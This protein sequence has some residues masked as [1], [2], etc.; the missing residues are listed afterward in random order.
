MT[1]NAVRCLR[2]SYL[3]GHRKTHDGR[4]IEK[5]WRR[6]LAV[7]QEA[8]LDEQASDFA[9]WVTLEVLEGKSPSGELKFRLTDFRRKLYGRSGTEMGELQQKGTLYAAPIGEDIEN[10]EV[11][12]VAPAI[13]QPLRRFIEILNDGD[14]THFERLLIWAQYAYGITIQEI[15]DIIGVTESRVS[16]ISTATIGKLRGSLKKEGER[17][18]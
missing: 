13:S 2:R 8:G 17:D 16:Q 10:G 9:A 11:Q 15:G 7:G 5:L 6:A 18:V 14:L 3:K 4:R 1:P 12:A